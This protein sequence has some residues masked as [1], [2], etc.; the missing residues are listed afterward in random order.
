MDGVVQ[1]ADGSE[2]GEVPVHTHMR[3]IE[4]LGARERWIALGSGGQPANISFDSVGLTTR[5]SRNACSS[6]KPKGTGRCCE[7][8]VSVI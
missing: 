1:H 3:R 7:G 5:G 8:M 6:V 2:T 4:D